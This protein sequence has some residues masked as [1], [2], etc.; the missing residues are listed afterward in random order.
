[1]HRRQLRRGPTLNAQRIIGFLHERQFVA[2]VSQEPA[3]GGPLLVLWVSLQLN[4][5]SQGCS[6]SR[7]SR[8]VFWRWRPGRTRS[9]AQSISISPL[10]RR[11]R[12]ESRGRYRHPPQVERP[13]APPIRWSTLWIGA[14]ISN[15]CKPVLTLGRPRQV[16]SHLAA[17]SPI[18][19]LPAGV[20]SVLER[21]LRG[22][23]RSPLERDEPQSRV[24]R[25]AGDGLW[26][27]G[28]RAPSEIL[29]VR[30]NGLQSPRLHRT[31]A[32]RT[33]S[34]HWLRHSQD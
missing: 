2:G 15:T 4:T 5:L 24:P 16:L 10:V 30:H 9:R 13:S 1:M 17:N 26:G 18:S 29:L 23:R 20:R 21:W 32:Q 7:L 8:A 12:I 28:D 22:R 31:A 25:N 6:L 33:R 14:V 3:A 19:L 34:V 11:F 27:P